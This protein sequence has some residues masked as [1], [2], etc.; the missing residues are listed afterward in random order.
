MT[1]QRPTSLWRIIEAT[2][3]EEGVPGIEYGAKNDDRCL[4][5]SHFVRTQLRMKGYGGLLGRDERDGQVSSQ[6]EI[7]PDSPLIDDLC[8]DIRRAVLEFKSGLEMWT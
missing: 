1:L 2:A 6:A 7:E 5:L 8:A 4:E 3:T